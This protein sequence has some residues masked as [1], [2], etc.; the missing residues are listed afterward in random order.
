MPEAKLAREAE[1]PYALVAL[2]TDYDS[3]RQKPSPPGGAGGA[4]AAT[5]ASE[6]KVD[7]HVLL[8]EITGN[9]RAASEN[10]VKLIRRTIELMASRGEQLE[11]CPARS[12]LE[13]A[14]WS[15]KSRVPAAEIER[16]APLWGRYF[17][18]VRQS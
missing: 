18:S 1:I 9:L 13:L 16:L 10:A 2:V 4:G 3:W 8:K 17:E 5:A 6:Q 11:T 15:D 14:I 7:P 12:A